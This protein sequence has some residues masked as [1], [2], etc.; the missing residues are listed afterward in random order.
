MTGDEVRALYLKFFET[1]DHKV[2]PSSS[3]V[4][5]GDPTLLLTSAGMVQI[6]PYFMGE[7]VPPSRRLASCQ[8]C[9][10]TTDI[11]SVGDTK[12]LTFF[13]MLGNFSVGDY[14]KQEAIKWGWEFVTEWL[15]LPPERLWINETPYNLLL[16]RLGGSPVLA[17]SRVATTDTLLLAG[18]V[19]TRTSGEVQLLP[20]YQLTPGEWTPP[21]SGPYQLVFLDA[22]G[23]EIVGYSRPFTAATTLRTAS[24][25]QDNGLTALTADEAGFFSLKV[26]YPA[27]TAKIQRC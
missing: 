5:R 3:L 17:S 1:K 16:S 22:A 15:K 25:K 9:F 2:I 23:Q 27:A 14:F 8:K 21:T 18:G 10:R 7:A 11:E 24:N 20:W 4:P 13:E 26:P 12:H 6:K 19:I